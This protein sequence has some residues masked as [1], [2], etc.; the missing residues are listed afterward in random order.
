[1]K[2]T[3]LQLCAIGIL[4]LL[5]APL[6]IQ[7]QNA[8]G[9]NGSRYVN[10]VFP[11]TSK[12][13]L[14]YGSNVNAFGQQQ[15][16][17]MDVTQP[18][19]DTLARRPLIIW[20]FGGGFVEGR[21]EDMS[22]F[23]NLFAQKGYVCA[24]IDY[25][26]YSRSLPLDSPRVSR[27]VVQ[28]IHDMKAAVRFFRKSV[29]ENGNPFKID[30]N[31]II[32]GGV[33]AGAIM[34]MHVAA[35]D[36]TDPIPQ[37]LRDTIAR[38]GG[39]EGNSGNPGYSSA[40]KGAINMSGA[41]FR[42]EMLDRNDPPFASFHG[43]ADNIVAYGFGP[44]VYGFYGDGSGTLAPYAVQLGI[45]TTLQSVPGGGHT[46][47]YFSAAVLPWFDRATVF[48]HRLICGLPSLSSQD[49]D[50]QRIK[51]YP[52]PASESATID[53]TQHTEGGTYDLSVFDAVGRQVFLAKNQSQ[54][55]Y[56]LRKTDVQNAAGLYILQLR[57]ANQTQMVT[58]KIVFE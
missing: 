40:V 49:I 20:A 4:T 50:N 12:T 55:T 16:L 7:A 38:Q 29:K 31:N 9:C 2:K 18:K 44:N 53:L 8:L 35:M 15:N 56:V 6:S 24:S 10:P 37:F 28:A 19:N 21:R 41:L 11:D 52:N 43:T 48:L 3:V 32:V 14:Q 57:F 17:L 1:M 5:L 36:E 27:A 39:F 42:K 13:T 33:S 30:T 34:S 46:D 45:P 54:N 23:A 47:I 58:R 25:R 26:L 51:V 22:I